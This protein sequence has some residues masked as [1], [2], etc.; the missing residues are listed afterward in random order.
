MS[1]LLA[2]PH[3]SFSLFSQETNG[4]LDGLTNHELDLERTNRS[5]AL[6]NKIFSGNHCW[7]LVNH[8]L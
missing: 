6:K 3:V 1:P 2:N 7:Y 4:L 8:R 5:T